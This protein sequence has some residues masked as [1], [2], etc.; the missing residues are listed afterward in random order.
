M[1]A[2]CRQ[3]GVVAGHWWWCQAAD[4][5]TTL[6]YGVEAPRVE[7]VIPPLSDAPGEVDITP[8]VRGEDV[9]AVLAAYA[10][11]GRVA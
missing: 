11:L 6:A 10:A 4:A 5:P 7:P 1:T 3:C 9:G 8:S 2:A